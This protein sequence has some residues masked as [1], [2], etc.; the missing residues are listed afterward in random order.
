MTDIVIEAVEAPVAKEILKPQERLVDVLGHHVILLED[1]VA[2]MVGDEKS[3]V[4]KRVSYEDFNAIIGAVVNHRNEEQMEGFQLPS[5][6]FYFAKSS[7][8]IQ[9]S[10]YYAERVADMRHMNKKYTV[11]APNFI[12]SHQLTRHNSKT[13]KSTGSRYY[14]TNAKV[15]NLPKTFIWGV[16]GNKH[17]YLS[18]FP[19]TYSEGNMCYG[20]NS[21]PTQF[22]ENNLRGLDWYYQFLFESPFNND[23]GL[24]AVSGE[25]SIEAWFKKLADAAKDN[26]PFPYESLRGFKAV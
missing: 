11:R 15:G 20:G 2:F 16:D 12:I 7:T 13:W 5:N 17:I 22:T 3:Q 10:C 25:P 21:M 26:K 9:L 14:A 24:R 8:T 4:E 18:P 19:N 23:L 6:C 1:C